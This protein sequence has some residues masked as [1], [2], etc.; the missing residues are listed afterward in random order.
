M[1]KVLHSTLK[2]PKIIMGIMRE[3]T[4]LLSPTMIFLSINL[5]RES[6]SQDTTHTITSYSSHGCNLIA[7]LETPQNT[8]I[9]ASALKATLCSKKNLLNSKISSGNHILQEGHILS[10]KM[11]AIR[12]KMQQNRTKRATIIDSHMTSAYFNTDKPDF[13]KWLPV[14]WLSDI[15]CKIHNNSILMSEVLTIKSSS[16]IKAKAESKSIYL[17]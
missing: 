13:K 1:A 4:M 7:Y 3:N 8:E 10:W 11:L 6:L 15:E 9:T 14:F 16:N 2:R 17:G 5:K 12:Q